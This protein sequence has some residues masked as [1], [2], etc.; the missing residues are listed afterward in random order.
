[1]ARK[2][3]VD[4][5]DEISEL[6]IESVRGIL[7]NGWR[8]AIVNNRQFPNLRLQIKELCSQLDL[9]DLSS[10]FPIVL[11]DIVLGISD[12]QN[13]LRL[14]M[15]EVKGPAKSMGLTD[16]SQMIGYLQSAE[17]INI[18]VL[19]LIEEKPTDAP[20][21]TDLQRVIDGGWLLADW[22]CISNWSGR[23]HRYRSAITSYSPGGNID[24]TNLSGVG[25]IS[26]WN[27]FLEELVHA[28][29]AQ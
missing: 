28:D 6:V 27:E 24:W 2:R 19:L 12:P 25:G 21:S 8:C 3:E 14:A 10:N 18:G 17:K 23:T 22:T 11:P 4:H 9:D 26:N 1:M 16:Y 7:P 5:Y 29:A 13:R 20:T 15:F